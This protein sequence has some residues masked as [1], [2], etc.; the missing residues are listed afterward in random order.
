MKGLSHH[1]MRSTGLTRAPELPRA[2][3]HVT[4]WGPTGPHTRTH[5]VATEQQPEPTMWV[6]PPGPDLGSHVHPARG[7]PT[8][9]SR[10]TWS[11]HQ[12]SGWCT[13]GEA[14]P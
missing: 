14:G 10:A 9:G 11:G 1:M 12:A 7:D 3:P 8:P 5:R 4:M 6:K 13:F 2:S